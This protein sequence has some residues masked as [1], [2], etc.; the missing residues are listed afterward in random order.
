MNY[1]YN[2]AHL[3]IQL[4]TPFSID[5]TNESLP[6]ISCSDESGDLKILFQTADRLPEHPPIGEWHEEKYYTKMNGNETV[7][8][9]NFSSEPPYA[10]LEYTPHDIVCSYL[11]ES[12][13]YLRDTNGILNMICL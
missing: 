5:V 11:Q 6:F 10:V 7:F 1:I 13:D 8:V 2:L 12:E 4:K 9:R 3:C